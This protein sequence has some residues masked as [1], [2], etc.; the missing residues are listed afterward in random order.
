MIDRQWGSSFTSRE[1]DS[2]KKKETH[3][4]YSLKLNVLMGKARII[5]TMESS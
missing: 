3:G 4:S 2:S 5:Y 1:S